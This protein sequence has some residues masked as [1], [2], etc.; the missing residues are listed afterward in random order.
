MSR[1]PELPALPTGLAMLYLFLV[2]IPMQILGALITFADEVLYPWYAL[3][4]R[5]WGLS[6]IDDQKLGGLLMWVPGNLWL[7]AAIGILFFKW[8]KES[9]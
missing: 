7:F 4:P 9:Q 1:V 8:A 5:T 3:A 2:G 6:P